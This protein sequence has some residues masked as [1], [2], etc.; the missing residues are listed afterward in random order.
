LTPRG[1]ALAASDAA[2][3]CSGTATRE[4]ALVNT[5]LVVVYRESALNW[6]TLGRLIKV[7]HYGLPNLVAGRRVAPELMQH[8]F[9][10]ERLAAELSALLEPRRNAETRS[11]LRETAARLGEGGASARAADAVL[12]AVR[13]WKREER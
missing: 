8:D 3:V 12:R 5:P 11:A 2:A 4:A 7:E 10:P 9:T 1:A 6:H 13:R